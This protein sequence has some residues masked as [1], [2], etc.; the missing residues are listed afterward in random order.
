MNI[1][2][3]TKK[4]K[5]STKGKCVTALTD[6]I[7]FSTLKS[8]PQLDNY[9]FSKFKYVNARTKGLV[10][11]SNPL[12]P[13]FSALYDSLRKGHGCRL[14]GYETARESKTYTTEQFVTL[15]L[16]RNVD[17]NGDVYDYSKT[18]YLN[19]ST[20]VTITCK[21]HGD[22]ITAPANHLNNGTGCP[23]CGKI[24]AHAKFLKP[25]DQLIAEIALILDPLIYTVVN[26]E[27][28][29]CNKS[30][31][32]MNC[33]LPGHG[34]WITKPN[35][36][37]SKNYGCTLCSGKG[38]SDAEIE[39]LDYIKSLGFPN[40]ESGNRTILKPMELDIVIES[41]KIAFEYNGLYWH[42]EKMG[43]DQDYHFDKT[44]LARRMGYKLIQIYEDE[45]LYNKEVT[46]D[47]IAHILEAS[48]KPRLHA[49]KLFVDRVSFN[50]A[51]KFF[52]SNHIQ[53][54]P[55]N[56]KICY[57]LF[58]DGVLVAAASFGVLRF[59]VDNSAENTYE[60]YRY[61][62]S[63]I[64]SGGCSKLIAAFAKDH[65]DISTIYSFSDRRWSSGELYQKCGFK[66]LG[67]TK[68][69]YDYSDSSGNRY[70]R[71]NFMK[72]RM[73]DLVE[74]KIFKTFDP[75][76]TEVEN[77]SD[78]GLWRVWNCGM[79]RWELSVNKVT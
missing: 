55:P 36:I 3:I 21:V 39:L 35:W 52:E 65:T 66:Y 10:K 18:L 42:S 11:C 9:D 27:N 16:D 49:R 17:T 34:D 25:V 31:I 37:L 74:K 5:V 54:T 79:D 14:C 2:Q 56:H 63:A 73:P 69:S 12:H 48:T 23:E 62:T 43:K 64:I 75:L 72:I 28:Y 76:K 13:E 70:N 67:Y 1:E 30:Y 19:R 53:G 57:G 58:N 46:K 15:G 47:K 44:V 33:N 29:T 6:E 45:W 38:I 60:L 40:A 26:T 68:P 77:C 78:N 7:I 41:K 50:E 61:A 51:K 71:Q 32:T 4:I 24:K 59:G 22:F 8:I 20:K